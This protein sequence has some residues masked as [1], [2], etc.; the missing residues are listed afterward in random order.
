[1]LHHRLGHGQ[2]DLEERPGRDAERPP[3]HLQDDRILAGQ[4]QRSR[5]A[6]VHHGDGQFFHAQRGGLQLRAFQDEQ[7]LFAGAQAQRDALQAGDGL[8]VELRPDFVERLLGQV[9]LADRHHPAAVGGLKAQLAIRAEVK[10]DRVAVVPRARG[11]HHRA[12][13]QVADPADARELVAQDGAF[14]FELLGVIQVLVVAAAAGREVGA[15]RLDALRAGLQQLDHLAAGEIAPV[16]HQADARA[17]A[18]QDEGDEDSP[19]VRQPPER[20]AAV[21]RRGEFNIVGHGVNLN[22]HARPKWARMCVI[23]SYNPGTEVIFKS[24]GGA[25]RPSKRLTP[26]RS[27][28]PI[29]SRGSDDARR[30]PAAPIRGSRCQPDGLLRGHLGRLAPHANDCGEGFHLV[31]MPGDDLH[32]REQFGG[33]Q[34]GVEYQHLHA[35]AFGLGGQGA[36]E[37]QHP[38]LARPVGILHRGGPIGAAAD[39]VDQLARP[40]RQ[41]AAHGGHRAGIRAQDVGLGHAHELRGVDVEGGAVSAGES[42]VIDPDI[43]PA[44]GLLGKF[45]QGFDL[46]RV[47]HVTGAGGGA[48]PLR[49]QLGSRALDGLSAA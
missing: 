35:A 32:I 21:N 49:A 10:L 11:R 44:K 36:R 5:R 26:S 31:F 3:K 25:G 19:P 37:P 47:S 14:H 15:A 39:Q 22:T 27:R 8:E 43:Q 42:R 28:P 12:Q 33:H 41:E 29:I 18:G 45:S 24:S 13:G 34:A 20:L 17:F 46:E 2:V 16:L 38:D 7:G 1:M 23:S 9:A 4:H 40:L 48:K 30:Q 6:E